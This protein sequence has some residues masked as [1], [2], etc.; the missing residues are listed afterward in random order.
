MTTSQENS[1]WISTRVVNYTWRYKSR[2]NK[3]DLGH[4]HERIANHLHTTFMPKSRKL[5]LT[6][7]HGRCATDLHV[8]LYV[9]I[10]KTRLGWRPCPCTRQKGQSCA[11]RVRI[12]DAPREGTSTTP[13]RKGKTKAR[14][15]TTED[16]K[17]NGKGYQPTRPQSRGAEKPS[18]AAQT[19]EICQSKSLEPQ[20]FGI[21]R[22]ADSVN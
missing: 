20:P 16:C 15:T 4:E 6:H 1:T 19:V 21:E 2:S 3:F 18:P 12:V 7:Q 8:T 22:R 11:E 13:K 14:A 17:C 10:E 9:Q 5:N